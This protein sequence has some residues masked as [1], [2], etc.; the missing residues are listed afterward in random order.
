[1]TYQFDYTLSG[2]ISQD[3]GIYKLYM[4]SYVNGKL[5]LPTCTESVS[6]VKDVTVK[7]I[8]GTVGD[9]EISF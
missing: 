4:N 1:M 7:E 5:V 8:A 3:G 2:K 9:V 6:W